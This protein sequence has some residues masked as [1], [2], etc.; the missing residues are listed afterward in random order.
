MIVPIPSRSE[1]GDGTKTPLRHG[2]INRGAF[3]GRLLESIGDQWRLARRPRLEHGWSSLCGTSHSRNQDAVV[4]D[5]PLFAVADGVGGGGAGELASSQMLAW[6]QSV[7]KAAWSD[8]VALAAWITQADE[9]LAK[10]LQALN[11]TGLSAT[12]FAAAWVK[13]NGRGH[14]V[15][16]GDARILQ[17][18]ARQGTWQIQQ[19]TEDHTYAN[20]G[21]SPP[22]GGSD[23]DPARMVG[24]GVI[25]SPPVHKIR[26]LEGE[27][28]LFCSDGLHK[29]ISPARMAEIVGRF[30]GLSQSLELVAKDM[31]HAALHAGS[32]DDISVL[33]VRRNP[34]FGARAVFWW[35]LSISVVLALFGAAAVA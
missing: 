35:M 3:A 27:M 34:R 25:G 10:S 28:L 19:L 11:P 7:P 13:P 31:A 30:G 12:I 2:G 5:P 18:R 15:H 6:C 22:A 26:L 1:R 9:V 17:A 20:V 4:A 29:F 14:I 8:E 33:L 23:E 16:V 21:E 32:S 24:V